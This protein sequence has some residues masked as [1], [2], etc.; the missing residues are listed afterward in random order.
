MKY[1][2]KLIKEKKIKKILKL[3]YL[4]FLF[5]IY[6]LLPHKGVK[7]V[8][9]DWD[10]LIILDACRYDSFKKLNTIPGK[11][12]K[13]ISLGSSTLEWLK[14]NF[15]EYYDDIVYISANP[16]ISDIEIKG[17]RLTDRFLSFRGTDHFFKVEKVWEYGWDEK[18]NTV[19]P[20]VVTEAALQAKERYPDKRLIIH[21]L[22]PHAPWIGKTRISIDEKA[23]NNTWSKFIEQGKIW[24]LIEEGIINIEL[25]KKAYEDNLKLVLEEVK[26]LIEKLDGKIVITSDHGECFGEKFIFEHPAGIYIKELVEVP[27]LVIEKPRKFETSEKIKIKKVVNKLKFNLRGI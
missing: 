26:K 1:L 21:Y 4:G 8:E 23:R 22:Q 27:W 2:I 14:K 24:A 12:E 6:R 16:Y 9:E 20:E 13:K 19:P 10:Y 15:D 17:F 25:A 7:V 18:L 3:M 11:L 5:I